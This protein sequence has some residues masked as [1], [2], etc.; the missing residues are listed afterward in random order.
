MATNPPKLGEFL[1]GSA[2]Q[3]HRDAIHIAIAPVRATMKLHPG[4]GIGFI[5]DNA[6]DVGLVSEPLGIV[7][8]FLQQPIYAGD[9]FYMFLYPNTITSL[10]HEWTHPA[11]E[12][13]DASPTRDYVD[14]ARD[15]KNDAEVEALY[16]LQR[17][18]EEDS[19]EVDEFV[20]QCT[21]YQ[22]SGGTHHYTFGFD[23]PDIFWSNLDEM[24]DA[25]EVYTGRK[26]KVGRDNFFS[27][28][29]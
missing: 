4:Q 7:D 8:P 28:A 2:A 24:W 23:T 9:V 27:C 5:S 13:Q 26:V 21:A 14:Q 25:W 19:M 18:A 22:L 11:F 17:F 6:Y 3:N 12:R 20:D 15:E 16:T 29:C 10:R 1:T